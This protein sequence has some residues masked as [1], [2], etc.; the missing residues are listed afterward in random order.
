MKGV[1]LARAS[2]AISLVLAAS[3]V[4][5]T[6][7]GLA[8]DREH[9][10][11]NSRFTLSKRARVDVT[12]ING[13]VDIKAIDGDTAIVQVERTASSRAELDCNKVVVNHASGNL[14]VRSESAA[15][16][17]CQTI[18]VHH[19]VLLS[20]PRSVDVDVQGVSGPI[21]IREIEGALHISGNSGSINLEQP[22][23]GSSIT[24]NA[25]TTTVKLR[26]RDAGGLELSGNNGPV[27]LYIGDKVDIDV[28]VTELTGSVSSELP[29]VRFNRTGPADYRARIGSGGP[30]I[31]VEHNAGDVSLIRY[32]E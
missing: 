22:G 10:E 15:R 17:G 16:P 30:R 9:D 12:A 1:T 20:L 18:Q 21:N 6:G 4:W 14:I 5:A 23:I 2:V 11:S 29:N 19:R 7:G 24:G 31:R 27:K 13:S 3:S 8:A 32:R 25:G 26:T 28:S